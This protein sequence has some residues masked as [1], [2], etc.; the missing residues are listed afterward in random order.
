MALA[1]C[2]DMEIWKEKTHQV[3]ERIDYI[4]MVQQGQ[5]VEEHDIQ[6]LRDSNIECIKKSVEYWVK[7]A[8]EPH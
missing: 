2:K 3:V 5:D 4:S 1:T 7:M 6:V 8:Q